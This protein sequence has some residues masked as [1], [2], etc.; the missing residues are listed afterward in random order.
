[1]LKSGSHKSIFN[2]NKKKKKPRTVMGSEISCS[3]IKYK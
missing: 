3:K 2:N 1:M